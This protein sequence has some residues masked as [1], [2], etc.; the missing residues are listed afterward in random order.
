MKPSA[1]VLAVLGFRIEILSRS[2]IEAPT[3][4]N[5]GLHS[6]WSGK[7][8]RA[9]RGVSFELGVDE[10]GG[11]VVAVE[12]GENPEAMCGIRTMHVDETD[13]GLKS[14]RG[15]R[16]SDDLETR[17]VESIVLLNLHVLF[18]GDGV[19]DGVGECWIS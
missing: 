15:T 1:R 10:G 7:G 8:G 12:N 2:P 4:L 17:A 13:V 11:L 6:D 9:D 16:F 19:A 14:K 18:V 5:I 3:G